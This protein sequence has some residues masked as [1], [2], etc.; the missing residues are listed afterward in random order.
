[1]PP[2]DVVG[3]RETIFPSFSKTKV[4][5]YSLD[6]QTRLMSLENNE[7]EFAGLKDPAIARTAIKELKARGRSPAGTTCV[8]STGAGGEITDPEVEESRMQF[9]PASAA[10]S[11]RILNDQLNKDVQ[12]T[13][14]VEGEL[15]E[16]DISAAEIKYAYQESP[17]AAQLQRAQSCLAQGGPASPWSARVDAGSDA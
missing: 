6:M 16:G 11:D 15:A 12:S 1:M 3:T 14:D 9:L 7:L 8:D 4:E 2:R 5:G 17:G 13:H 10:A